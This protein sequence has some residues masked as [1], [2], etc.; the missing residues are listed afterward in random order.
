MFG[1]DLEFKVEDSSGNNSEDSSG[2]VLIVLGVLVAVCIVGI[3]AMT[4]V[5]LVR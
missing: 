4:S 2:V 1:S 3:V 5:Y